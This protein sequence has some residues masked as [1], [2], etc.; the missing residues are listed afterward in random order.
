MEYSSEI[1]SIGYEVDTDEYT[2]YG[3]IE[4]DAFDFVNY[5]THED[6]SEQ[7]IEVISEQNED[8]IYSEYEVNLIAQSIFDFNN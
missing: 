2:I 8:A 7:I 4:L 6:I 1:F 5:I 3:S